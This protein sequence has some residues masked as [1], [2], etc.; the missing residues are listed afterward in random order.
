MCV[1]PVAMKDSH[2]N[3]EKIYL[4]LVDFISVNMT[5]IL[6]FVQYA[7]AILCG[8]LNFLLRSLAPRKTLRINPPITFDRLKCGRG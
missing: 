4:R 6:Y 7:S 2:V 1:T 5:N 3:N 8:P